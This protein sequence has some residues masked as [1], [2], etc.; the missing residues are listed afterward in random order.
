MLEVLLGKLILDSR[1]L[2][3]VGKEYN[4]ATLKNR[5]FSKL[6]RAGF[7]LCVDPK[8]EELKIL[9]A[10]RIIVLTVPSTW[11]CELVKVTHIFR[12]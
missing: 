8:E 10:R 3:Q 2:L 5:V 4:H 11:K 9:D 1:T 12:G 7:T 6:S